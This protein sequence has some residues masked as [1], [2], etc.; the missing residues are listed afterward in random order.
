M[1]AND[2]QLLVSYET[3]KEAVLNGL[4]VWTPILPNGCSRLITNRRRI[5][6]RSRRRRNLHRPLNEF[7]IGN[8]HKSAIY[9]P[10]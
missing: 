7:R 8:T 1:N 5:N 3:R 9:P 10:F 6:V 2:G 4:E